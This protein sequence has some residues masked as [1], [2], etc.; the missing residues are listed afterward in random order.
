MFILL[1]VK[2]IYEIEN[3]DEFWLKS[4]DY[5][6]TKSQNNIG[7][8]LANSANNLN[9]DDKNVF[10]IQMLT[11]KA[12]IKINPA[13]FKSICNSTSLITFFLKDALEFCGAAVNE[14]KT[15]PHKVYNTLLYLQKVLSKFDSY[16][17]FLNNC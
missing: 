6:K 17:N 1:D 15:H 7:T 3:D 5:L 13:F 12:N 4:C 9:F 2:E 11:H 16:I 10:K 14:R 8:Y